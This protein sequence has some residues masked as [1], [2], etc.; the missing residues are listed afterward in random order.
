MSSTWVKTAAGEEATFVD[1]YRST[2]V[3][4]GPYRQS[5]RDAI[6]KVVWKGQTI[7]NGRLKVD[8]LVFLHPGDPQLR[9][10]GVRP[11]DWAV[12]IYWHKI[13][14]GTPIVLLVGAIIA[15]IVAIVGAWFVVAKFT[16]REVKELGGGLVEAAER[17]VFNPGLI[18][19]A[20]VVAVLY[21]RRRA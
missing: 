19:A 16:E 7:V 15:L 14:E 6:A 12:R 3:I 1:R 2:I 9:N 5:W 8:S 11:G 18:L 13:A 10:L 4:A 21:L 20:F 17:T